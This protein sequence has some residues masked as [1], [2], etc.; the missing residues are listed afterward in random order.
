MH[1]V[2]FLGNLH[3]A[4][5]MKIALYQGPGKI[6]DVAGAWTLMA[7]KAIEAR[8]AG[9]SLLVLPEMYLSGYNIGKEAASTQALPRSGLFPAQE[10]ARRNG[11]AL[12]FGY[13]ERVGQSVANAACLL[14]PDGALLL[15]YRKTHLFGALD[16][17]MFDCVGGGFGLAEFGGFRIGLL[18]CYDIEFPESARALALSG[19]DILLVP[20]AQM[21]PYTQVARH[22]IP[23]RA[24]ENQLYLA[25]ANHSGIADGLD[26]VG[27][28]SICGPDGAILAM[29]GPE[30]EMLYAA[31]D[32]AHLAKVRQIDTLIAD[33]RPELYQPLAR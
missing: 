19:A 31:A 26:Y 1:P 17:E 2:E 6:N 30:E 24:Y 21:Q 18:I 4:P 14:G 5:V 20:T 10:I 32:A 8:D 7:E 22:L 28:S 23:T 13:P 29:A 25:Y 16:R 9:A 15:N 33:R 27:L 12:A 11:I 3:Y